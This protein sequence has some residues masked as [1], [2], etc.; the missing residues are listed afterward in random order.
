MHLHRAVI[1][2]IF[3]LSMCAQALPKTSASSSDVELIPFTLGVLSSWDP[4]GAKGDTS[5]F[6][7]A[8]FQ[9]ALYY[10]L[11]ENDGKLAKCGYRVQP[12]FTYYKTQD[13]LGPKE[14]AE[15]LETENVWMI[16]GP[17]N[18]H[19]YLIAKKG[20]KYT[21]MLTATAGARAVTDLPNPY[22]T[23]YPTI[24]VLSRAAVDAVKTFGY[25]KRYGVFVDAGCPSCKDFASEFW[26][27]SLHEL[28][29]TFWIDTVGERP[30][31][32]P[33]QTEITTKKL[34]FL[35]I[36]NKEALTGYTIRALHQK[37]PN[38]KFVG[39]DWWGDEQVSSLE[40]FDLPASVTG[41]AVNGGRAAKEMSRL[42]SVPSLRRFWKGKSLLPGYDHFM[43]VDFL[44]TLTANLCSWKPKSQEEFRKKLLTVS[45]EH[46]KSKAGVGVFQLNGSF[47]KFSHSQVGLR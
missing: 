18:S 9:Q 13:R 42:Y 36:P 16:W 14:L 31:L 7:H 37:F 45:R 38:L 40:R 11:G 28:E 20:L 3:S 39:A 1:A 21:P 17:A 33:L 30:D 8:N 47:L 15:Q 35:L 12:Q 29:R 6:P 25:G 19:E 46:F 22:F 34:D 5:P 10:S 26:R 4:S 2:L 44:R 41:I 32:L 23:M 27:Q 43:I 24:D